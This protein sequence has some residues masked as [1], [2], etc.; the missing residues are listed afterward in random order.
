MM[1]G[2]KGG[3]VGEEKTVDKV[4]GNRKGG[5]A[6]KGEKV[7]MK[8]EGDEVDERER[9]REVERKEGMNGCDRTDEL[10]P[11]I[12]G[13]VHLNQKKEKKFQQKTV[14]NNTIQGIS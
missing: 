10:S 5:Q 7:G 11:A 1:M 13:R 8:S 14:K 4:G 6:A 3:R 2:G 9:G 12:Q